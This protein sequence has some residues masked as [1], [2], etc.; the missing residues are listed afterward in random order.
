VPR[1]P[2]VY[3]TAGKVAAGLPGGPHLG[4]GP[5]VTEAEQVSAAVQRTAQEMGGLYVLVNNAGITRD[6]LIFRMSEQDWDL[7]VN[8]HLKG[9]FLFTRSAQ[10]IF[11]GHPYGKVVNISSMGNRDQANYPA[12]K[13]GIQGFTRTAA[14]EL[15]PYGVNVNAVASGFVAA[16]MTDATVARL[17]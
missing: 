9:T 2:F 16:E 13:M 5:D 11:V 6:N 17:G 15:G 4:I 10:E 1:W 14:I 12:A 3:L 8:V 7:I